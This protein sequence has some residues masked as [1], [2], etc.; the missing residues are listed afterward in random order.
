MRDGRGQWCPSVEGRNAGQHLIEDHAGRVEVRR[1][2]G[3]FP[4]E[5]FGSEVLR[6]AHEVAGSGQLGRVVVQSLGD[7]EVG[8]LHVAVA[9]QQDVGR[10]HVAVH[11]PGGVGGLQGREHR[12]RHVQALTDVEWTLD[13]Q[14]AGQRR[15]VDE[16][17]DEEQLA[18]RFAGVVGGDGVG[19]SEAGRCSC[20]APEPLPHDWVDRRGGNELDGNAPIESVVVSLEHVGHATRT[21]GVAEPIAAG[22]HLHHA[23]DA[24]TDRRIVVRARRLQ[25]RSADALPS[26]E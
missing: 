18:V 22:D 4:T 6:R 5:L 1:R 26:R 15:S 24:M 14:L 21:D 2:R 7:A 11:D 10:L 19:M 25:L 17:H 23:D 8:E 3:W 20:L 16:L 12:I 9:T 13:G